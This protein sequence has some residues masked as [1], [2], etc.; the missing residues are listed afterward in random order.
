MA[1]LLQIACIAILAE[2]LLRLIPVAAAGFRYAYWRLVLAA[3]L[4]MPWVLRSTA[5]VA[6]APEE[7]ATIF[8]GTPLVEFSTVATTSPEAGAAWLTLAPWIVATGIA[9]R[10]LWVLGGV[11]RLRALRRR[12]VPIADDGYEAMQ[13]TLGTTAELRS[14]S[15]LT[16]PITFGVRRPV[17]LLPESL[18]ASSES[19][20]RAVVAH[21]LMHVRR[22]DWLWVIAEEALRAAFWFHPAIWWMTSRIQRTREEFTDH[23][24]VL[25]TGSRRQYMEA[26]L[27]FAE[28]VRLDPAPAFARRPH[29]FHRIVLLSKEPAMSSRRVVFSGALIAALLVAGSWY[30]T[31]AFPVR[32]PAFPFAMP[33]AAPPAQQAG[34][35]AVNPITPENPVPRRMFATPIPYP[36]ELAG[37]G[38]EAALSVRVVLNASGFVDSAQ[39]SSRAVSARGRKPLIAESQAMERF[40]EAAVDAVRQWQY[41]PPARA[42]IAFYI[43]VVF[44]PDAAAVVAQHDEPQGV[45]AGPGGARMAT[46]VELAGLGLGSAS[47]TPV[48]TAAPQRGGRGAAV[49]PTPGARTG[50]ARSDTTS[51]AGQRSV[52]Q[53]T[54]TVNP[55]AAPVRVG[56]DVK[57][58]GQIRRVQPIYPEEARAAGI[59]GVVILEALLNERG[60]VSSVRVLRSIPG[61]DQAAIEAVQQWEYTPTLLNGVP[62]PI[63]M[64]TTVQFRLNQ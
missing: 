17:V 48:P 41:A 55:G 43:S 37:T 56:G 36:L 25:A 34:A 29:L 23:L 51:G 7:L 27:A 9:A 13:Q 64:T 59:Q 26:L 35:V 45:V 60:Y 30:A 33:A 61:L 5:P 50:G 44:K 42:P 10:A 21:E 58:P 31:E 19:I 32:A 6:G 40:A 39:A 24:A 63:I 53:E 2:A 57:A 54:I 16:Q 22:R 38:F 28:A 1:Y 11:L 8:P 46:P 18:A 52:L 20:R 14:V 3:A 47:A 15:D 49:S 62:V 12:G 4:V